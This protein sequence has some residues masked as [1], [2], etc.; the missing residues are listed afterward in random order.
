MSTLDKGQWR[1]KLEVDSTSEPQ[2]DVDL[3]NPLMIVSIKKTAWFGSN[4][5]K[6]NVFETVK[7]FWIPK[8]RIQSSPHYMIVEREKLFLKKF[9]FD[10][11][12]GDYVNLSGSTW[13]VFISSSF[14]NVWY[15]LWSVCESIKFTVCLST[16]MDAHYLYSIYYS[17]YSIYYLYSFQRCNWVKT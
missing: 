4:K 15:G 17:I 9:V 12:K 14:K 13:G 6:N 5:L 3:N 10:I 16:Y 2:M 7:T 11:K 1:R 8:C